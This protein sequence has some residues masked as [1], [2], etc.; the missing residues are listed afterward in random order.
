MRAAN[1][2]KRQLSLKEAVLEVMRSSGRQFDP[3][4]VKV[5]VSVLEREAP[6]Q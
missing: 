4:I 1:S 2:Y 5:F 6:S 3:E